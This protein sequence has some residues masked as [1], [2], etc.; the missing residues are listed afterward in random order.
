ML[1]SLTGSDIYFSSPTNPLIPSNSKS[2]SL[3]CQIDVSKD[4]SELNSS[5]L[6]PEYRPSFPRPADF[7]NPCD[8]CYLY[9]SRDPLSFW[10]FH[11]TYIGIDFQYWSFHLFGK[12]INCTILFISS[13]VWSFR[14]IVKSHWLPSMLLPLLRLFTEF[15]MISLDTNGK[16]WKWFAK[17]TPGI[18]ANAIRIFVPK[19]GVIAQSLDTSTEWKWNISIIWN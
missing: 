12:C 2:R 15:G 6:L 3:I 17:M 1:C 7:P 19:R 16:P 13:E 5:F 18:A 10:L 9:N 8:R 11:K 4:F 14:K